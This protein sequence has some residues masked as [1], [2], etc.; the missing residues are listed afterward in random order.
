M[1]TDQGKTSNRQRPRAL[2]AVTGRAIAEVGTTTYRPPF[3]PVPLPALAGLRRGELID[4]VRRLPLEARIAR[5]GAVFDEYGGW[6]RPAFYGQATP[7]RRDRARDAH[8]ARDAVGALRRLAAR[9]DRGDRTATRPPSSTSSTTTTMSTLKPGRLRYGFLLAEIGVVFDD[10]VLARLDADRF[11]VS[12]SSS[13][14]AAVHARLEDWRQ[15]R[16]DP[17]ASS[18]TTRPPHWT[19]LTV[20]GPRSRAAAR[21]AR[22]R[23]RPRRR[24]AAA[25]GARRW[26]LRRRRGAGR[27]GQFHRRPLYEIS[28]ARRRRPTRCWTRLLEAGALRTPA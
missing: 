20:S 12:C 14:V 21:A 15:D 6:L 23:R 13:H 3:T 9:Q 10:G 25:H 11:V 19:T 2:A 18:S 4:P 17:R 7:G 26:P 5:D 1:A 8:G 22:A 24:G 28:R 16:F 27:A